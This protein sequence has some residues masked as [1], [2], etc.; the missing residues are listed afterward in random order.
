MPELPEVEAVVARARR[1]AK[2][3][4]IR[5]VEVLRASAV[6]PQTPA[7]VARRATDRRI[8]DVERRGKNILIRL[9]G[10]YTIRIHLKLNGDLHTGEVNRSSRVVFHLSGGKRLVFDEPRALGTVNVLDERQLAKALAGIGAEPLSREFKP[11]DFV[12]AA[13][14]SRLAA[15]LFLMDQKRVAGLGNVY[16]AE[17]L[18]RARIHPAKPMNSLGAGKVREL[19]GAIREVL[20]EAVKSAN[21]AYNRPG[22]H[23]EAAEFKPAVYGRE[24]EPC[25]RCGSRIRRIQQGGRSTYFC[26]HCQR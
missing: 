9:A 11:A 25:V 26:A 4:A 17:A 18:F 12:E 7:L 15:K 6:R 24:G 20:R 21:I 14:K 22:K 19:H 13:G 1:A 10:G 5:E 8:E 16:A 2:G 3:R 23:K